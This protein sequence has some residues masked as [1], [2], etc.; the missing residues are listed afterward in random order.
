MNIVEDNENSN[1]SNEKFFRTMR[2]AIIRR[3]DNDGA[4]EDDYD[5]SVR[6]IIENGD[7][8]IMMFEGD[9]EGNEQWYNIMLVVLVDCHRWV[10]RQNSKS[11]S[12]I[13]QKTVCISNISRGFL[14]K[15]HKIPILIAD[16]LITTPIRIFLNTHSVIL[17]A[18]FH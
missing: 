2:A 15:K 6:L 4:N 18:L 5:E 9:A 13:Y 7:E 12:N 10:L 1:S 3:R 8:D 14:N 16:F 11:S 17:H